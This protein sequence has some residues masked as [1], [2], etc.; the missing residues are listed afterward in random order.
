MTGSSSRTQFEH[1][2]IP[3]WFEGEATAALG[4]DWLSCDPTASIS[5]GASPS[6]SPG[7]SPSTAVAHHHVEVLDPMAI[8]ATSTRRKGGRAPRPPVAAHTIDVDLTNTSGVA[9]TQPDSLFESSPQINLDEE[10]NDD[11][12]PEDVT[13]TSSRSKRGSGQ[14]QTKGKKAKTSGG[15]WFQD[16]IGE[17]V[18]MNERTT[19]SC[20]S[21]ASREDKSGFSINEVMTLVK[22][23][24][25]TSGTNE[26][27]IA[28][29]AFTKRA[30]R[31]MFMILDTHEERYGSSE[32]NSD[33][34]SNGGG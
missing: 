4:A 5:G 32:S 24:G 8:Q 6:I 29:V 23:C 12:D 15:Q 16:K 18:A 28:T 34:G 26:H 22:E 9:P 21:M 19:A 17:L 11:S 30:E 2:E 27:F 10:D 14:G 13:P 1:E 33:D 7:A 20:E 3:E 25:A 31:E